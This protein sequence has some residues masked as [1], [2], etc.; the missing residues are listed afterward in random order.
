MSVYKDMVKRKKKWQPGF[1]STGFNL[2]P[3]P[4]IE[5]CLEEFREII[6]DLSHSLFR[7][8]WW[9]IDAVVFNVTVMIFIFLF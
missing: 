7:Q 1:F 6:S 9:L 4:S 5:I 2:Y 8:C 3:E